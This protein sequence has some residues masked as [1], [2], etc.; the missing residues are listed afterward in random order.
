ME[1]YREI[2][3]KLSIQ[4]ARCLIVS[5]FREDF[6]LALQVA[7]LVLSQI[8]MYNGSLNP[9]WRFWND[10]VSDLQIYWGKLQEDLAKIRARTWQD[11]VDRHTQTF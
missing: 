10:L 9:K 2:H 1:K 6:T 4:E 5:D 3:L 11:I 8:D 7:K